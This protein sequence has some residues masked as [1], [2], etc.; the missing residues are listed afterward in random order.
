MQINDLFDIT[1]HI[2]EQTRGAITAAGNNELI[3][4]RILK[5]HYIHT[6][7]L[8]K[9]ISRWMHETSLRNNMTEAETEK[10]RYETGQFT[11]WLLYQ[12][13]IQKIRFKDHELRTLFNISS[14]DWQANYK[15][16]RPRDILEVVFEKNLSSEPFLAYAND[17][18]INE[19]LKNQKSVGNMLH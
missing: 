6:L 18:M 7:I 12:I 5:R 2:I 8:Q 4:H 16:K 19:I 3:L 9:F 15:T 1:D 14:E 11:S 17:F 10:S 13:Y